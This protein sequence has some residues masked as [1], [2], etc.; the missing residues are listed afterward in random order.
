M[1]RKKRGTYLVKYVVN[2]HVALLCVALLHDRLHTI[3]QV[4]YFLSRN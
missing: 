4:Q 1:N 2:S 3:R